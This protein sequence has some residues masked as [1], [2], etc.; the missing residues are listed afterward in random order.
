MARS[1]PSATAATGSDGRAAD[2]PPGPGDLEAMWQS[3]RRWVA[4]I[5]LA[6]MP[7]EAD[8]EDLLQEVAM[9]LVQHGSEIGSVGSVRPWLRTVAVNVART[10]GRRQRLARSAFPRLAEDPL[11]RAAARDGGAEGAGDRELGRRVLG[12]A[13]ELPEEYREPLLLRAVRGLSYRQIADTLGLP[14]TTVETRLVRARRMVRERMEP[15]EEPNGASS[16]S[17]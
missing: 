2:R 8:V 1:S 15:A 3:H 12:L 7:R 14:I 5:L 9:R 6:H 10:H 4:A 11:P 13:R 16:A 17:E